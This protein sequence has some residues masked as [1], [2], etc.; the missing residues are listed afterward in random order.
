MKFSVPDMS[1]NHCKAA[2]DN[3]V[4]EIDGAASLEF[5][6]ENR[7]VAIDSTRS[8]EEIAA[9]LKEAGYDSKPV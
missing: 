6:L 5:D 7:T 9:V 4:K 1:C 3:A 2:I 8:T